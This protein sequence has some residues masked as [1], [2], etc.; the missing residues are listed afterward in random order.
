[1]RLGNHARPA[2]LFSDFV[3]KENLDRFVEA[4]RVN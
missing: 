2:P 1:M 4:I 3:L